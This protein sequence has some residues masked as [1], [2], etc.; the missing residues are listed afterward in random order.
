MSQKE[1]LLE[2]IRNNARNTSL[3]DFESLI[4]AYGHIREG[5][6]HPKA[7]IGTGRMP[8]KR[9]NPVKSC[10]VSELLSIIEGL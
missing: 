7:I 5:G 8:Y 3:E 2:K 6:K 1:K 4:R 9:E 10:Y